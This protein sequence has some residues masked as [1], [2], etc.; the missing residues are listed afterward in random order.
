MGRAIGENGADL[1]E[2]VKIRAKGIDRHA[3][4][5]DILHVVRTEEVKIARFVNQTDDLES[6]PGFRTAPDSARR[7][8]GRIRIAAARAATAPASTACQ[9]KNQGCDRG[10]LQFDC[11]HVR[12]R[13]SLVHAILRAGS[14]FDSNRLSPSNA[15]Q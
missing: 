12:L 13:D 14:L 2:A 9:K 6:T 7:G 3:S 11:F 10:P 4:S 15:S 8:V 5:A 1:C